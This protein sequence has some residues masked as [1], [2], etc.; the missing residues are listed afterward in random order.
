MPDWTT[1]DNVVYY[2]GRVAQCGTA[3][4]ATLPDENMRA[5]EIESVQHRLDPAVVPLE[6]F[7]GSGVSTLEFVACC[8]RIVGCGLWERM[9]ELGS[10]RLFSPLGIRA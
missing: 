6:I 9:I 4:A 7:C 5:L 10:D 1:E 3:G 8:R 2:N